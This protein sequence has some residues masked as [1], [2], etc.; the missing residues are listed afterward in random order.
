[1]RRDVFYEKI[2]RKT[3]L[4]MKLSI[5]LL[6][7]ALFQL[8]AI[9]L[10]Q[11]VTIDKTEISYKY[12]FKEIENQT[13]LITIY[14]NSHIDMHQIVEVTSS[15]TEL[16]DLYNE[17]LKNKGL[18]FEIVKDYIVIKKAPIVKTESTTVMQD[19]ITNN[20]DIAGIVLDNNSEVIVGANV[21]IVGDNLLGTVTDYDGKFVLNNLP[22]NGLI[23]VSFIGFE[24]TEIEV[25][26]LSLAQRKKIKVALVPSSF[27]LDQIVVTGHGAQKKESVVSAISTVDPKTLIAPTRSLSSQLAGQVS[28][29]VFSQ[30]TGEPGKDNASFIIRGINSVVGSSEPLVLIDGLKR[31]LNDVDPNDIESFSVLKDASATA[32]YG[33]EGANGILVIKTKSGKVASKPAVRFTYSES[34]NDATFKP[35]WIESYDYAKTLN[36][37]LAVRDKRIRYDDATLEKFRD[38][39]ND[40]YPNSDWYN[41]LFKNYVSARKGNFNISGGGNVV[42]Y[43]M[44]AGFYNEKGMFKANLEDFDAN[45]QYNSFNFRSNLKADLTRSTTIGM[46]FDGN[47][48]VNAQPGVGSGDILGRTKSLNPTLIPHIFSNGEMPQEPVTSGNPYAALNKTGFTRTY[49]NVMSTNV[50][51][52]QK[53]NFI[54]KNLYL[55]GTASFTKQNTQAHLYTMKYTQHII[56]YAGSPLGD[57]Y[58][59]DGNLLTENKTKDVTEEMGFSS[60]PGTGGRTVEVQG[61]LNYSETFGKLNVNGFA[62]YRQREGMLDQVGGA[63]NELLINALPTRSQSVGL[64]GSASYDNKYFFDAT[65]NSSGTQMFTPD[66]RWSIFPSFGAGYIVSNEGYWDNLRHVVSFLKVRASYGIAGSTGGAARFGYLAKALPHGGYNFGYRGIEGSGQEIGGVATL[67]LEQLGLSWEKNKQVDIGVE[68]EVFSKVRV[69]CDFYRNNRVNQ[70]IG[71]RNLPS[72]MGL[73]HD[74]MV[75]KGEFLSEGIDID[76]S[77]SHDFGDFKINSI[78]GVLGYNRSE[79]V[80]NGE[81]DAR[82]PYLSG[83]GH[84]WGKRQAFISLGYF[85]DQNDIENSPVQP[86]NEVRPGDIKYKDINGD[87]SINDDDK[88]WVGCVYPT[89]SYSFALSLSYKNFSFGTRLLGKTGMYRW[90]DAGR[91]PFSGGETG[92]IYPYVVKDHYIPASYSGTTAT[93]N[94]KAEFPRLGVGAQNDNN[95]QSST[96]W[97]RDASYLRIADIEL[98]YT[99]NVKKGNYGIKGLY[100]FARVDNVHTFS[101]FNYWNPEQTDPNAY[102]LKRTF[103]I[104]TSINFKL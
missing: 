43:Y 42:T 6:F 77:M 2:S 29:V 28:G 55:K 93:E 40:M 27:G 44:S 4:V 88:I 103:S 21:Y 10:S 76:L 79:I 37:A 82:I 39:N 54:S 19:P 33:L 84:P 96:H 58:D 78:R 52:T 91:I 83:I 89:L 92:M 101:N 47:Y 59:E 22:K 26:N 75:N 99:H 64:R 57:G 12:L 34:L 36:E 94:L 9:S 80:E 25:R 18:T 20:I 70:L 53:L 46:G 97:M 95:K 60:S 13:G 23:R 56:D 68:F 24:D 41:E 67:K 38:D 31:S 63:A 61:S 81:T 32:I 66:N 104:G 98:G 30:E 11:K 69:I 71:L 85:E 100:L 14:N 65:V 74:P 5:I 49:D 62:L 73:P 16:V 90:I 50:N 102:P 45:A 48:G 87:G 15:E 7:S 51:L 1:M 17:V 72:T 86:W 35:D 8:S 3:K